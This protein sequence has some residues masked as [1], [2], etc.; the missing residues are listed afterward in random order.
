M[1]PECL[2][3]ATQDGTIQFDSRL[4]MGGRWRK[5]MRT[6]VARKPDPAPAPSTEA[7]VRDLA[8]LSHKHGI[9][10]AGDPLLFLLEL[11]DFALRYDCDAESRLRLA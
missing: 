8:E 2:E 9:G 6:G 4:I 3:S 7:F 11:D 1:Q 5:A 10:I